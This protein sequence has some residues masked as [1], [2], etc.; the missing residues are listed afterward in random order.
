[1]RRAIRHITLENRGLNCYR[2]VVVRVDYAVKKWPPPGIN[3]Q[4]CSKEDCCGKE[5]PEML[6]N[7]T[8]I[9]I[10]LVIFAVQS[11]KLVYCFN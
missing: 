4:I 7:C 11:S 9:I 10:C 8:F 6:K 3:H 2:R 1:M 5:Y